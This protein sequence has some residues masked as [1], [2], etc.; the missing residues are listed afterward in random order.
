MKQRAWGAAAL[1]LPALLAGCGGGSDSS[2]ATARPM[3][4][5]AAQRSAAEVQA[6][7]VSDADVERLLDDAEARYPSIFLTHQPTLAA[8]PFRYRYYADSG[9]YFG[10]ATQADMGYAVGGVYVL[11]DMFGPTPLHLGPLSVFLLSGTTSTPEQDNGCR[12]HALFD[13]PGTRLSVEYEHTGTITG[14]SRADLTVLGASSHAGRSTI[15]TAIRT[16]SH[17]TSE[18]RT[19]DRLTDT[20]FFGHQTGAGEI[21]DLGFDSATL[22]SAWYA[23]RRQD[24]VIDTHT[25]YPS[26]WV[27]REYALGVGQSITQPRLGSTITLVQAAT[28]GTPQVT[29]TAISDNDV[30]SFLGRET[31][32]VRAGTFKTCKF[33]THAADKP[34]EVTTRWMVQGSGGYRLKSET[35]VDG[36]LQHSMEATS[37]KLGGDRPLL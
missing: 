23:G 30:I 2:E 14:N 27:Q 3:V 9:L 16:T 20:R 26:G 13:R 1:V 35:T 34:A 24:L 36:L 32:T 7:E 12:N 29:T 4:Q 21:T 8:A 5:A 6:F 28:G 37:F 22:Q 33:D 11:S 10:V 17:L 18:G 31:I 19:V 25:T 15:E